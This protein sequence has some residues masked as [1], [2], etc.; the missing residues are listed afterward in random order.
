MLSEKEKCG[1]YHIKYDLMKNTR[2]VS[3]TVMNSFFGDEKDCFKNEDELCVCE[4]LNKRINE[5][6]I[7]AVCVGRKNSEQKK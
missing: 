7:S 4:R 6:R 5:K 3:G 2:Y 1:K